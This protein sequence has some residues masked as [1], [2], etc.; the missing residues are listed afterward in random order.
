[1]IKILTVVLLVMS[2][3]YPERWS[4]AF[5]A[6]FA[7]LE[8][9]LFLIS[10]SR[11]LSLYRHHNLNFDEKE[12]QLIEKYHLYFR[13]PHTSRSLSGS[14]S[15]IA[16]SGIVLGLWFLYN[17]LWIQAF[18]AGLNY[19]IAQSISVKLNIRFYLHD[20]V[21]RLGQE[22]HRSEMILVDSIVDKLSEKK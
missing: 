18:I 5:V 20:A 3:L 8:L 7:I 19:F 10:K 13:Y 15:L 16:F 22:E 17:H 11:N 12:K 21:E 14:L 2:F 1:M 9:Y 4:W 6:F